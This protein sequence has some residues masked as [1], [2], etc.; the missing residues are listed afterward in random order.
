MLL[1]TGTELGSPTCLWATLLRT[2]A[3]SCFYD[4]RSHDGALRTREYFCAEKVWLNINK[5]MALD[6]IVISVSQWG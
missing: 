2:A 3:H 6:E 4:K 1:S 5:N